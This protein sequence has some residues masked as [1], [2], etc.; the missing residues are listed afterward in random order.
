MLKLFRKWKYGNSSKKPLYIKNKDRWLYK[1]KWITQHL[2]INILTES[3]LRYSYTIGEKYYTSS[4][5]SEILDVA[6][7]NP[8]DIKFVNPSEFSVQELRLLANI[9]TINAKVYTDKFMKEVEKL[10]EQL[11]SMN[12]F[13]F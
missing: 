11:N 5:F 7:K 3:E 12:N 9:R 1:N 13:R 8:L 10:E 6:S 4:S 2:A